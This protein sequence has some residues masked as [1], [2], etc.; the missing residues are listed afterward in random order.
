MPGA[1]P[2][3]PGIKCP[4]DMTMQYRREVANL[5]HRDQLSF[6]GAQPVS[7]TR[8]HLDELKQQ[9]YYVCE[10]SD[11]IR[12]LMYFTE[13]EAGKEIHYLIDR[14]N[15]YYFVPALHFPVPKDPTFQRFHVDTLIDGELVLDEESN[16][17]MV[18]KYLVFDCLVLD[19]KPLMHRTLDKR[20]AYFREFVYNPYSELCRTFPSEV[21]FFPFILEFKHMEFSYAIERMFNVIVPALKHGTDGLIFTCRNSPYKF[22]TDDKILK[23]KPAEENSIDFRLNLHFPLYQRGQDSDSDE[24]LDE[25]EEP[26]DDG[27]V[28]DYGAMPQFELSAFEGGRTY[29]HFAEMYMTDKEWADMKAL[30]RP[31]DD[32]IVECAMDDQQRWRFLRFRNDKKDGNHISV[33]HSVLESIRDGVG[34][35]DLLE[36]A[37]EIRKAWKQRIN[38]QQPLQQQPQQARPP[39]PRQ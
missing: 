3:M 6:P 35:T 7:F 36:E 8:R 26:E 32:T 22:G 30:G 37:G 34:K 16:G 27:P 23:W 18:L 13:D 19:G 38:A 5:I 17:K 11:G 25:D 24:D 29:K 33:V 12:C 2:D 20:L 10:K 4:P 21:P 1:V 15:D 31:L 28:Y 9:D 14:R 39:A